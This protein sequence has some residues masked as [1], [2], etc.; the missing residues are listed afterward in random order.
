MKTARRLISAAACI[1]TAVLLAASPA[2]SQAEVV[3]KVVADYTVFV[4]PPTGFVF[5]K[6]PAGWKFVGKVEAAELARLPGSVVTALLTGEHDDDLPVRTAG[7]P[8]RPA[9][10][11]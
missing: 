6:L 9:P 4:D 11:R 1:A 8:P 5:V 2:L 3:A 10:G 7:E